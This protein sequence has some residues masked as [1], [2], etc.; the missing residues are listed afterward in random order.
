MPSK[1]KTPASVR[2]HKIIARAGVCSLRAAERLIATGEVSLNGRII[3]E[4]GAAADPETDVI[5]V[6]G[7]IVT[8]AGPPVYLMMNKPRGVVTTRFDDE[9]RRTVMDLLP[10]DMRHLYPVGRLDLNSE[11]LLILT[12]DGDFA[13]LILAPKHAVERIYRVKVRNIPAEKDLRKMKSGVTVDGEKLRVREAT[14]SEK[15]GRGCWM[16]LVLT[17]GKNRHI[18]RLLETLGFPVVKLKRVG[19]GSLTLGDLKTGEV[20]RL[21][22]EKINLLRK[23]ATGSKDKATSIRISRA[24]AKKKSAPAPGKSARSKPERRGERPTGS[25]AG[26][27]KKPRR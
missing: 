26:S 3:T 16:R 17:E 25:L 21:P 6:E 14:V 7:K 22:V 24:A 11:G 12:N 23:A 10:T 9:G 5:R 15:V 13:Q 8:A 20:R 19:L 4:K 2:I 1:K 18:R 27:K